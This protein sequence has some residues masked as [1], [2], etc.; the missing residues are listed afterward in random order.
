MLHQGVDRADVVG[1]RVGQRDA[2]QR[3]AQLPGGA[4]L[5]RAAPRKTVGRASRSA[6]LTWYGD[7]S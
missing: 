7:S 5:S 3:E 2:A 6:A 1:V 4:V